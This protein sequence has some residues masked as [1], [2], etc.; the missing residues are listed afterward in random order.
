MFANGDSDTAESASRPV[1]Q[2]RIQDMLV[3]TL[4]LPLTQGF[5]WPLLGRSQVT[6]L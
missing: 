4:I 1:L 2:P 6:Q 5:G 3:A